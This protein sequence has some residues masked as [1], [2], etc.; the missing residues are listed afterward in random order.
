MKQICHLLLV[1]SRPQASKPS[2]ILTLQ[3][4]KDEG[5]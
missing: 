2:M 3:A 5:E 4:T 1:A